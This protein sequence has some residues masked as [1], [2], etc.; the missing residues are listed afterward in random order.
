[1]RLEKS[2]REP[3]SHPRRKDAFELWE[4]RMLFYGREKKCFKI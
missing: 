3:A 2:E 1:M 4:R